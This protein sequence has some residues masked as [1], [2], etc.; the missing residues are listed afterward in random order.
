MAHA[1]GRPTKYT[2]SMIK[3]VDEYLATC[4][5]VEGEFHKTRG[6]K[7]DSFERTRKVNLPKV[8]GFAS[9]VG[10]HKDTLIEWAKENDEF[11]V[12]LDKIREA[13]HNRLIDETLSGNYNPVIAKLILSSNHG[14]KE[15][16]DVTSDGEK[17]SFVIP[18]DV[19]SKYTST[20]R[21]AKKDSA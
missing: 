7:S 4:V 9:F 19:A 6:E 15:K 13:Q 16:S 14:Y 8:E 1:G 10:V 3:K 12:A 20:A 18:Q 11:S 17:I 2:A 21:G 5:D